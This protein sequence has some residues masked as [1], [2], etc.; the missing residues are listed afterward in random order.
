MSEKILLVDDEV[1]FL[2]T[3]A[4]RMR[5]RGLDV[6]TATSATDALTMI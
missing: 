6:T 3:M 1:D 2:E 4:E 5:A